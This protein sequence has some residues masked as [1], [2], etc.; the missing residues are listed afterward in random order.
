MNTNKLR[1]LLYFFIFI[2][3]SRN[4]AV[5]QGLTGSI[6]VEDLKQEIYFLA[7]DSLKGRLP[8]TP[9]SLIAA[10]YIADCFENAGLLLHNENGMQNF[11]IIT[12]VKV[13]DKTYFRIGKTKLVVGEDFTPMSFSA[14]KKLSKKVAFV[15]YGFDINTDNF[16]WNDYANIDVKDKWVIVL[17]GFPEKEE[18]AKHFEDFATDRSKAVI[19]R[20]KGAAGVLFVTPKSIN[21]ADELLHLSYDKSPSDAGIPVANIKRSVADLILKSSNNTIEQLE[22][23]ILTKNAPASFITKQKAK[24]FIGVVKQES[25]V[26]N[27]IAVIEGGNPD[28]KH[29]YI[30]VGAHYDHLGFGGVGSGSRTPDLHKVHNGADDNASGVAG[31][32]E[33]AHNISNKKSRPDRSILFIAFDAEEMGLLGSKEFINNPT[34]PLSNIKAMINMD[35]IGRLDSEKNAISVGGTKTSVEAESILDKLKQNV[36][37]KVNYSPDGYGPSDHASFYAANIPVF[38]FTTGAHELYHTPDDDAEYINYEGEVEILNMIRDLIEVLANE[39][40][41]LTYQQ[42]GTPQK[43]NHRYKLKVTLG[44]VPDMVSADNNGLRVDGVRKG[45]A[46]DN[47]GIVKGDLIVA[48]NGMPITNIYDY[49]ARLK[50]LKAGDRVNVEYIRNNK[51]EIAIIQF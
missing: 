12:D 41:Q 48:I 16:K 15:G 22:Q 4:V 44:I 26:Q 17:R 7:S 13:D 34:V 2:A 20:D 8:G 40:T 18:Y 30:V 39:D 19:A 47:A 31:L 6:L 29:E 3:F 21:E 32:I 14:N 33:L 27:V 24:A 43:A 46:A 11:K 50:Q 38:Y 51:K 36:S 25:D 1:F 9:E 23:S 49:M 35:M 28:F 37:F 5:S 10:Q 42:Y 45:G